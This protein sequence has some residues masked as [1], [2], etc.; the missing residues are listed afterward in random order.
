MILYLLSCN[1]FYTVLQGKKKKKKE[2]KGT[3]E[4]NPY[5]KKSKYEKGTFDSGKNIIGIKPES[6]AATQGL[7]IQFYPPYICWILQ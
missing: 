7:H 1:Y 3:K 5:K 4:Q 2:L 6:E